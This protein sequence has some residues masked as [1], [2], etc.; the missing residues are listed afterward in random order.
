MAFKNYDG[1]EHFK[2]TDFAAQCALY[3]LAFYSRAILIVIC[4]CMLHYIMKCSHFTPRVE[5]FL[6]VSLLMT[7]N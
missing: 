3:L 6:C 5:S 7:L 4:S 2:V 1:W